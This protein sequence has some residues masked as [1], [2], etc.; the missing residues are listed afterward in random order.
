MT[1]LSLSLYDKPRLA[2]HMNVFI[3]RARR[4][5]SK[6]LKYI[7][8]SYGRCGDL[9]KQYMSP[10][11]ESWNS[12]SYSDFPIYQT[13]HQFYDLDTDLDIYQITSGF[14]GA[15]ASSVACKQG[16]FTLP[17]TLFCLPFWDLPVLRLSRLVFSNSSF[18]WP[19]AL[20]IP[21]YF[22]DFAFR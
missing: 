22:F 11:R 12:T 16:T 6:L 1:F 13:F 15:F 7:V 5:S 8:E 20:N 4:L 17:D 19:F 2:P 9:I 21:R 10:S 14:N 3:L 18:C